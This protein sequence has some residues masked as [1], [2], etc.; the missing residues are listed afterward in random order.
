MFVYEKLNDLESM[1]THSKEVDELKRIL[2]SR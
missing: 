2:E 1:Q